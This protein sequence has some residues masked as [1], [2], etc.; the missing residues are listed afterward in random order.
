MAD[1]MLC[2]NEYAAAALSG[3]GTEAGPELPATV[4][5]P[6]F[7][8]KPGE[9]LTVGGDPTARVNFQQYCHAMG[10][11]EL[12]NDPRFAEDRERRRHRDELHTVIQE[13]VLGFD[14]V[15]EVDTALHDAGFAVGV[16]RSVGELGASAW[17]RER[18]SVVE[19]DD[20]GGGRLRIPNSPWRFSSSDSGARGHAAYRGEHN[21]E[22]L[23]E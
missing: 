11:P 18:G 9:L 21:R 20:R 5:S 12:G 2:V 22:V 8:T 13:W 4:A 10:T 7:R 17:A 23:T 3:F 16:V 15:A 19:V 6:V 14:T 1:T